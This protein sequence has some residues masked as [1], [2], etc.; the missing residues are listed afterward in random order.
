MKISVI[1]FLLFW[2]FSGSFAQDRYVILV[3]MDG[4][5][6]DYSQKYYTPNL[7]KIAKK[8]VK[9][10][11]LIPSFPSVTFPNH[12]SIATGL[13]P[14]HHG[15]VHNNFYDST[16]R[17]SYSISNRTVVADKRFYGGEPIWNTARR[18]GIKS[19]SYFWVGSEAPVND[20]YAN[21]WKSYNGKDPYKNRIDTIVSW[22]N[23][24]VE[25]RPRLLMLY[26][27]EP[28]HVG[29]LHGPDS[30]ET[31]KVVEQ[32]DSLI[33]VLVA[34]IKKTPVGKKVDLIILSDHG[35][36]PISQERNIVLDNHVQGHWCKQ[37]EGHNPFYTINPNPGF[38]DS[39]YNKLK[40]AEH[41]KVWRKNEIPGHL[42][43][44]SNPR[45]FPIVVLADSGY[46][47]TWGNKKPEN[48]GAHGYDPR[49]TDMHGIFYAI[50]PHFKKKYVK[51]S[52]ENIQV[53]SIICMLLK[54]EA[55][56]N[57]GDLKI[58]ED[59]LRL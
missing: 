4:F 2:L 16:L 17:L 50:G 10:K 12:Y 35:M 15:L 38:E 23:L 31:Q 25:K 28:D 27:S 7:D 40:T 47:F 20:M 19:A 33:G 59:M 58:V 1:L 24:P 5:R 44:G 42:H 29:H 43:Y 51:E 56:R 3:S 53:Y 8:G 41:L 9:A 11:S 21:F 48:R 18:Q 13:Y 55:A 46:C 36:G 6:W 30:R 54:I 37:I 26:F 32:M 49:N 14:D 45:I 57:D 34:K 52:F 22:L 39:I